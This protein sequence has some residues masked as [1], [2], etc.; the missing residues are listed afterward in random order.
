MR[1][2]T[3]L[4]A[5]QMLIR[6]ICILLLAL[7]VNASFG[8]N[9][10]GKDF[11]LAETPKGAAAANS[12][13][14]ISV[15]NTSSNVAQITITNPTRSTITET[16]NPGE[17]KSF[18]FTTENLNI[19]GTNTY[20]NNVYHVTS[21][22][23][24]VV[25]SFVPETNITTNDAAVILPTHALGR[26]YYPGSYLNPLGNRT[27]S[28]F[29]VVATQN[30]TVIK[31]FN[32]AG[33]QIDN[34]TINQGQYFQ[35]N[36]GNP[37]AND[38][39]GWYIEASKPVAVFSG[40]QCTSIG[41][42]TF[43]CDLLMEQTL[44]VET[45]ANTYIA[46]PSNSRPINCTTCVPDVFRYVATEDNTVISTSPF[47]GGGTIN[48]GQFVEFS[49]NQPHIVTGTKP[50][51]GYQ[52]LISQDA[53]LLRAP[54]DTIRSGIGDPSLF[55][56]PLVAQFQYDFTFTVSATFSFKAINIVAPVGTNFKLDGATISPTWRN[57]GTVGG[58]A[59]QSA[60]YTVTAGSH[61]I[62]ADKRFGITVTAFDNF[63][64]IAYLGGSGLEPIN[65][66]CITGGPYLIKDCSGGPRT[67]QMNSTATCTDGTQPLSIQW[68]STDPNVTFSDA[69]AA[70][71]RVTVPGIGTYEIELTVTCANQITRCGT[72]IIVREPF[73][74]CAATP[75]P[76]IV[77]PPAIV[78]PN[79]PD[80]TFAT[81]NDIGV[82]TY[83]AVEQATLTHTGSGTYN[84]GST[85]VTWTVEDAYGRKASD[86]Q[87]ITVVPPP[88]IVAPPAILVPTDAGQ[89][90]AT[91]NNLFA[92]GY[93]QYAENGGTYWVYNNNSTP[94]AAGVP[95]GNQFPST[96]ANDATTTTITWTTGNDQW[97]RNASGT[98]T[99]TVVPPPTITAP[100][101]IVI[102]VA[103]GQTSVTIADLGTAAYWVYN[104]FSTPSNNG[105]ASYPLGTTNV[106]WT[107]TDEF[108]RTATAIQKVTIAPPPSIVPPPTIIVPTDNGQD[109]ATVNDLYASG[110]W[111]YSVNGGTYWVYNNTAI[112]TVSGTPAA[113]QYPSN[114]ENG[115][116]TTTVTWTTAT[117]EF[118][119][120]A[121]GTQDVIVVPPPTMVAPPDIIVPTDANA[122]FATITAAQIGNPTFWAYQNNVYTQSQNPGQFAVGSH[123]ITWSIVD[124]FGR[125]ATA[126]QNIT[127]VPAPHIVPPATIVVP[128]DA[129]QNYATVSALYPSGYWVYGTQNVPGA[130]YYVYNNTAIPT[131]SG[132]PANNQYPSNA[133][134]AATTTTVT[135]TTATDEFGRSASGT[136]NVVVVPPPTITA[137]PAI[138]V[139][140]PSGTSATVSNLGTANFWVYNNFS[141][142]TNNGSATGTY[143]VGT[144]TVTWTIVDQ[145]GR[146]ATATQLVTVSVVGAPSIT[147]PPAILVPTDAG[148]NYATVNTLFPSGYWVYGTTTGT[149][150]YFVN[151][152]NSVPTAT[153]VPSLNRFPSNSANAATTTTITWTTGADQFGRRASGTQNITV[154]PPP[155]ITAPPAITVTAPSGST[156]ATISNLG[157][158]TYWVYN[159]FST[160][161]NN[162]SATGSYPVG[163]TTVTWRVVDQ[164]G[165]AATATQVITVQAAQNCQFT[166]SITAVKT[167]CNLSHSCSNNC[168]H[169]NGGANTSNATT[170]YLG[171]GPQSVKLQVGVP[172]TGG[173]YTYS[174]TGTGTLNSTTS[175]APVFTPKAEG[176]YTFTVTVKNGSNCTSTSTIKICV[177]DVRV[178]DC[179]GKWDGKK[180][181]ICH[182]PPGNPP[183]VQTIS[184]SIN[185]LNTHVPNHGGDR[186]G[187][188]NV[189]CNVIGDTLPSI[190][191]P[192]DITRNNNNGFAYATGVNLGTATWTALK[193]ATV[194]NNAPAQFPIGTTTVTWTVTDR[195]GRTATDVQL[196][197]IVAPA[198]TIVAPPAK[199][200]TANSGNFA[201]GVSLGTATYTVS[202]NP[203][204]LTNNA[205][206]Q[207]PVGNTTVTWTIKDGLN[208]TATAT[209]VITVLPACQPYTSSISVSP[210]SSTYTGGVPTNLYLGYGA[211]SATL[212][213]NAPSTGA[214]YTYTWS[215]TGLSNINCNNGSSVVFT[216]R[217]EGTYT[218]SVTV[219]NKNG[220]TSTASVTF[221]VRDIRVPSSSY[222]GCGGS[223]SSKVYICYNNQTYQIST[224][225]VSCYVR[226]GATNARLGKCNQ[227]CGTVYNRGGGDDN[228]TPVLYQPLVVKAAPNPTTNYFSL[229]IT[230]GDDQAPVNIR[231]T[232]ALGREVYRQTTTSN[233]MLTVGQSFVTGV[234]YAEIM[235]GTDKKVVKL[236]KN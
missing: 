9:N 113:N 108:G 40:S 105:L 91:V 219:R 90:Y 4:N 125:V 75:P 93:W 83:T 174:W 193:P 218:L 151:G 31:T 234:Y 133:T 199:T 19:Q 217:S 36:N 11:W 74:G 73:E 166:T 15:S 149:G 159:N 41:N 51:Y 177:I 188:C 82:A 164:F 16:L 152:N 136:Q 109:Y 49:T 178:L 114:I 214:P 52:Y 158:A 89:N 24:I 97:G 13:F 45:L 63:A 65:A 94:T 187:K 98:Q 203:P 212:T 117:D 22:E 121:S 69:T 140:I 215:G 110:Y 134:N 77:A 176:N 126:V 128:T 131:V 112:P 17:L 200:V 235:Q 172:S 130:T 84:I 205:P 202:V 55:S 3:T 66:G 224:S 170:I 220:C 180:V 175:S 10:K 78:V 183:N 153:G 76:T 169:G 47:V 38:I 50:F 179:Y 148:Q 64:S 5:M 21:T 165:R 233:S 72:Q 12:N 144:T 48:K 68:T 143:P 96:S 32:R 132:A 115:T 208:R 85:I 204:T 57:V 119:R 157:T 221:C 79:D 92:S 27:G 139:T 196:V 190:I 58:V 201:T 213:V 206:A 123:T 1:T 80:E 37:V 127:V 100:A 120:S 194:T 229:Q 146:T 228:V 39:T 150:T 129:G 7:S 198:P 101:D 116:T 118:G 184:I 122:N 67:I 42:S 88:S 147:P 236:L 141:T 160:P 182:L 210:S 29:G 181:Y 6:S 107:V 99:I 171:Y 225:Q 106:T 102:P 95:S 209:Q 230:G 56:M 191:A 163:T 142:P 103:A 185:A 87:R 154:V 186:L 161:T 61:K 81:V 18:S 28:F 53:Y 8:Q 222:Y 33:T 26:K 167:S 71:P 145:F 195:L 162:G 189:T 60:A 35:R 137:P 135:W 207:F 46:A 223:S 86:T 54:G 62:E 23:L 226:A 25:Y 70:Q 124:S 227:T 104:N 197:T 216:P 14:V 156:S 168:S 44:P 2:S 30:G 232:D 231:V 211:Q 155:T 173:P 59:Y 20:V 111:V 43:A 192:A 34:V 138:T